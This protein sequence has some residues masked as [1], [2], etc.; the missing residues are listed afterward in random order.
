MALTVFK[1]CYIQN[2]HRKYS[3]WHIGVSCLEA[4]RTRIPQIISQNY[5]MPSII[6]LNFQKDQWTRT[7]STVVIILSTDRQL[8]HDRP[9]QLTHDRPG[10]LTHDRPGQLTHTLI[11]VY[12][13]HPKTVNKTHCTCNLLWSSLIKVKMKIKK[14]KSVTSYRDENL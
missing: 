7:N 6:A 11:C 13:T 4:G 8:T 12:Y 1:M 14:Y 5:F 10:Q 2:K 3:S 9:G